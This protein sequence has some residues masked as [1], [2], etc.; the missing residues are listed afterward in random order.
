MDAA[1]D[2]LS[3]SGSGASA[4]PVR[5]ET[6]SRLRNEL[7]GLL[8]SPLP[9]IIVSP[10][11][12]LALRW[13]A[14]VTGPEGTPYSNGFFYFIIQCEPDYP[15]SPPKV[16]LMTTGGGQVRFNPNLYN[17]G[18]VCL[19]ILGTWQG[20]GWSAA[21][22]IG[23]V[24]LSIQSLMNENPLRNEPGH[25]TESNSAVLQRYNDIITHETLRVAVIDNVQRVDSV[26]PSELRET[27]LETVVELLESYEET[28]DK[29]SHLD[30]REYTVR[31][32]VVCASL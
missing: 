32:V 18:K 20:P 24:L 1:W 27:M 6:L 28:C 23:S 9:G 31:V 3:K 16:K 7:R 17:S 15:A 30:G 5:P 29:M 8:S 12:D 26:M 10:D 13:H 21:L 22:T 14:L 25:E 2:P 4:T 11:P 19:S